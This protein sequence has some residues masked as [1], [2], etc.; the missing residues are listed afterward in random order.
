MITP[1]IPFFERLSPDGLFL[2]A[3]LSTEVIL[4]TMIE[5]NTGALSVWR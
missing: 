2:F 1:L 5:T 3:E 4:R